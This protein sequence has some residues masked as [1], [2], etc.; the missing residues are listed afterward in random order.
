MKVIDSSVDLLEQGPGIE[1]LY[2]HMETVGRISHRSKAKEGETPEDFLE[3]IRKLGHWAVFD[4][5]TVYLKVPKRVDVKSTYKLLGNKWT[6]WELE[7]DYYYIT[8]NYRVI[9]KNKLEDYMKEWWCD[10]IPGIHHLRATSHWVCSR[11][12]ANEVVR[13]AA[14]RFI[15]ESTRLVDYSRENHGGELVF[16][17]PE[18]VQKFR[19]QNIKPGLS[20]SE[21]WEALLRLNVPVIAVRNKNWENSEAEYLWEVE[22]KLLSPGD[23]RGAVSG[24]LRTE[25]YMCGYLDDYYEESDNEE[26]IGFFTL[27]TASAAHPDLRVLAINLKEQMDRRY[28]DK[29][30]K[31][32][33][34]G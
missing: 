33:G 2:A 26:K 11:N 31:L 7:G 25:F 19:P 24:D 27:R 21:L 4:L 3:R 5:G 30:K 34:N 22:E 1:G 29:D 23:A 9:L 12:I 10:A 14:F 20:N 17:A 13:H 15:Q 16:I 8:T 18:F 28:D 6:R 32:R